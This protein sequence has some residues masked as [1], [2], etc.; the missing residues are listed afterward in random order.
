[1]LDVHNKIWFMEWKARFPPGAVTEQTLIVLIYFLKKKK[2]ISVVML[3]DLKWNLKFEDAEL[4]C[5]CSPSRAT[6]VT[7]WAS[8]TGEGAE[9]QLWFL[10]SDFLL[11]S[12]GAPGSWILP[13]HSHPALLPLTQSCNSAPAQDVLPQVAQDLRGKDKKRLILCLDNSEFV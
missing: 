1:M 3:S 11:G 10:I 13:Q 9:E 2:G 6:S 8:R 5:Q 7:S 12:Q 4:F